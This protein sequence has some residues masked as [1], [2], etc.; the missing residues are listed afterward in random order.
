MIKPPGKHKILNAQSPNNRALNYLK[1]KLIELKGEI[2]KLTIIVED[3]NNPQSATE[4][5]KDNQQGQKRYEQDNQQYL[6]DTYRTYPTTTALVEFDQ[7]RPTICGVHERSLRI[8]FSI[9]ENIFWCVSSYSFFY[10]CSK[11]STMCTQLIIVYWCSL[12]TIHVKNRNL[13][14]LYA[15]CS[16]HFT[17]R[18]P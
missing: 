17:I 10:G 2:H 14:F 1:K 9:T 12:L 5:T 16:P 8:P 15:P 4:K 3:L 7:Q 6:I 13:V 11:Y 18:L